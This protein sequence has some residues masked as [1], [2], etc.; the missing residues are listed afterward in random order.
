[1][2]LLKLTAPAVL[3]LS[4]SFSISCTRG[5][6]KES[7]LKLTL[8]T[9]ASG[10]V[11][12]QSVA[13]RLTF[14]VINVQLPGAPLSRQFEFDD[15]PLPSNQSLTLEVPNVPKGT[16]L[17]QFIGV[18]EDQ[19]T[20]QRN[21]TYG[22]VNAVVG[23]GTSE[24][25]ISPV[26]INTSN[27]QGSLAG[28]ILT[29]ASAPKG[30]TGKL[31]M[32]YSPPGGK[33]KMDIKE[34]S[35]VDGWF[36][37]LVL[38]GISFD[39]QHKETGNVIFKNI[40][41][42]ASTV[43]YANSS[44]AAVSLVT[45]SNLAKI[46]IP[47]S[48]SMR[49][50]MIQGRPAT[51][52]Y[53]GYVYDGVSPGTQ[54]VCWAN[55]I[56]EGL[57][58]VYT[59]AALDTPL[60]IYSSGSSGSDVEIKGGNPYAS[61]LLY[62]DS[63]SGCS[64]VSEDQIPIYHT[65][66]KVS[67]GDSYPLRAPFTPIRPFA[68]QNS[69]SAYLT[70]NYFEPGSVPTIELEWNYLPGVVSIDGAVV[71]ALNS[72]NGG[73]GGNDSCANLV[74]KGFREAG[75]APGTETSF[76]FTGLAGEALSRANRYNWQFGICPYRL[77]AA[78]KR[79]YVGDYIS[80][81]RISNDSGATLKG[82]ASAASSTTSIASSQEITSAT[83]RVIG[84]TNTN[85]LYTQLTLNE[86]ASI[87]ENE[88]VLVQL[89]GRHHTMATGSCGTYQGDDVRAGTFGFAR[90]L[91]STGNAIYISKGTFVDSV[92]STEAANYAGTPGGPST[93]MAQVTKVQH[94]R[95]LS[96][97]AS[98]QIYPPAFSYSSVTGGDLAIRVNGTLTTG[99]GAKIHADE[100]GFSGGQGTSDP[101]GYAPGGD[102]SES[103][104]GMG[105]AG[106]TAGNQGGGGGGGVIGY[107]GSNAGGGPLFMGGGSSMFG[108]GGN[109]LIVGFGGGGGI[110]F[111]A[112]SL[113]GMGGSGG[114]FVLVSV[115]RLAAA[116]SLDISANG[117][118][119][120]GTLNLISAGGG[121]AGSVFFAARDTSA[122]LAGHLN[123][124]ANGGAGG[125]Y[126]ASNA[127]GGGAGGGGAVNALICDRGRVNAGSSPVGIPAANVISSAN[128]GIGWIVGGSN[129]H[130]QSGQANVMDG[131]SNG[132]YS[133]A[134][135]YGN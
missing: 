16:F 119:A 49:D 41:L 113:N 44:G 13:G 108:G 90:V 10:K 51:E 3:T 26:Q 127:L 100:K 131:S 66:L 36:S 88:E 87:F 91:R 20:G 52:Y 59:S 61:Y 37:I 81:G 62:T 5:A 25:I 57:P 84:I 95:N 4:F 122:S 54:K 42:E 14:A 89:V 68:G 121:G 130:G 39:Y 46:T 73:G 11:S 67:E 98:T 111:K 31:I 129:G 132:G 21:F 107:G 85:S 12:G 24:A 96:L 6:V 56:H 110:G 83:Q 1:V 128:G 104:N 126:D 94:Y 133:W 55:D 27:K 33:P 63:A 7:T 101:S 75:V 124:Q 114:G 19:A 117:A 15:Q 32:Q 28:R 109:P 2:R 9:K 45:G 106:S 23:N 43:K 40:R 92:G 60:D 17:V 69:E 29:R 70:G 74:E 65:M 86:T 71:L 97:A 93:C 79:I 53:V 72:T 120:S 18:Y 77:D 80:G 103:A 47:P 58:D 116:G 38:E 50:K 102:G 134:C 99:A 78:G 115:N 22:D 125:T 48:Y 8:P 30:P 118:D 76:D 64:G 82:W 105:G 135:G 112:P 35:I 34:T 123:F